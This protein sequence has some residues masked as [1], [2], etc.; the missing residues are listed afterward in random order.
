M[1]VKF[2]SSLA[3]RQPWW[4]DRNA[5]TAFH[6]GA[7]ASGGSVFGTS[8]RTGASRSISFGAPPGGSRSAGAIGPN[9][10]IVLPSQSAPLPLVLMAEGNMIGPR[11]PTRDELEAEL[12]RA[13]RQKAIYALQRAIS[14]IREFGQEIAA[15]ERQHGLAPNPHAPIVDRLARLGYRKQTRDLI[16]AALEALQNLGENHPLVQRL[17]DEAEAAERLRDPQLAALLRNRS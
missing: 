8:T 5:A 10:F 16:E 13:P 14:D 9:L 3:A 2:I 11:K 15:E 12:A 17:L 1:G 7:P 6:L 4:F